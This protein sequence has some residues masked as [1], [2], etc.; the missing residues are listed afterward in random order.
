MTSWAPALRGE[1]EDALRGGRP[2]VALESTLIS[3][4]LP[5]PRNIETA[6]R[7]EEAVRCVGSIPATIAVLRGRPHVG[8][9]RKELEFL[10]RSEGVRKLSRRDLSIAMARG[11][12]GATTV[13][14]TMIIAHRVGVRVFATGGI[15]GVHR[16]HPE[17]VSADLPELA[18]T[19]MIAVCAGAKAILDLPATLEW[20][21]THGVPVLGY[22]TDRFPEFYSAGTTLPVDQR[23]EGPQEVAAIAMAHWGWGFP[24][25]LLV[26]VPPPADAALPAGAIDQAIGVALADAHARGVRGG[27]LTPFL[28][29][30]VAQ[31]SGGSALAANCSLVVHNAGVGARI[32]VAMAARGPAHPNHQLADCGERNAP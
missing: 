14:G 10:A 19:P 20:L 22:G 8:L 23:I 6:L 25:S 24:S 31:L 15:G 28:L 1:V 18:C 11:L 5:Y 3:H 12:D 21:E 32:A 2:V 27:A 16:E 9:E 17:D 7:M 4:G 30:R 26:A 13:A 29:S